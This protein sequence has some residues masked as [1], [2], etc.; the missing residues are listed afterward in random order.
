MQYAESG[1]VNTQS[2]GVIDINS[3][4][5]NEIASL[6]GLTIIDAKKAIAYRGEHGYFASPDEFFRVINAKPH[7]IVALEGSIVANVQNQ[8]A[9]KKV[10]KRQLDL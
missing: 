10:N 2:A 3:A 4:N 1:A 9:T 8:P 5:E 7:I 6:R